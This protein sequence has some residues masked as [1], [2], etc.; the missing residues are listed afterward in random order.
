MTSLRDVL[1]VF[2]SSPAPLSVEAAAHRLH[3]ERGLLE[4]MVDFW[5]RKGKLRPVNCQACGL[6][7]NCPILAKMPT[8]YETVHNPATLC[9]L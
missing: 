2:E 8:L 5:V 7:G 1:A 4:S 3:M 9:D 6:R